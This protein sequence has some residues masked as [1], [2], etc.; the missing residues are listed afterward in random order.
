MCDRFLVFFVWSPHGQ[1]L[2]TN[3]RIGLFERKVEHHSGGETAPTDICPRGYYCP[4]GTKLA[5]EFACPNGTYNDLEGIS[6]LTQCKN[7]TQGDGYL[8]PAVHVSVLQSDCIRML[9]LSLTTLSE[10]PICEKPKRRKQKIAMLFHCRTFLRVSLQRARRLSCWNVL[11]VRNGPCV[12][13]LCW[14]RRAS[15]EKV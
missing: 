3:G 13:G 6:A 5:T 8:P 7:C 1:I 10:V 15:Q 14:T 2:L 4:N 11:S 12:R 9:T